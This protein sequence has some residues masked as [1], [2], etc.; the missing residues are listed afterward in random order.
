M[1]GGDTVSTILTL[2]IH[3]VFAVITACS[4]SIEAISRSFH[5][6]SSVTDSLL[7]YFLMRPIKSLKYL[8]KYLMKPR[9]MNNQLLRLCGI[10]SIQYRPEETT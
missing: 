3:Q 5:A 8:L 4:W 9:R 2:I 6:W 10:P 1:T 7:E